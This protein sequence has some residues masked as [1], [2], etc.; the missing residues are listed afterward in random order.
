MGPMGVLLTFPSRSCVQVQVLSRGYLL[1][2]IPN[3]FLGML[4][5]SLDMSSLHPRG[6]RYQGRV[7]SAT[8]DKDK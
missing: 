7:G 8:H 2:A 6:T 1:G 3:S 4:V 5:Y